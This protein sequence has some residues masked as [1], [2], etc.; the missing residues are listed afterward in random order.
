MNVKPTSQ[1]IRTTKEFYQ[2]Y[3]PYIRILD[4]SLNQAESGNSAGR[5]VRSRIRHIDSSHRNKFCAQLFDETTSNNI[6]GV[7]TLFDQV[8]KKLFSMKRY[9]YLKAVEGPLKGALKRCSSGALEVFNNDGSRINIFSTAEDNFF[10][11]LI[12]DKD[13]KVSRGYLI[14]DANKLVVNFSLKRP[15]ST[16]NAII[17]A[18]REQLDNTATV[19]NQD[20]SV[21]RKVLEQTKQITDNLKISSK[22]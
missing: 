13:N 19:L 3:K 7:K 21:V 20:L 18:N 6:N 11:L 17:Y 5:K 15:G 22:Q 4:E 8:N 16:P 2:W 9:W 14:E 1:V 12:K 10:K